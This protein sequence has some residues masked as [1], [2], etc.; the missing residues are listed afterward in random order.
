[1][2]FSLHFFFSCWQLY[3]YIF[4]FIFS[5]VPLVFVKKKKKNFLFWCL[6]TSY[7]KLAVCSI[8]WF[9]ISLCLLQIFSFSSFLNISLIMAPN[10]GLSK[11]ISNMS[12]DSNICWFGNNKWISFGWW[13]NRSYWTQMSIKCWCTIFG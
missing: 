3:I 7:R 2:S 6:L 13:S 9:L 1:M 5:F 10:L 4:F 8:Y 11:K 12:S